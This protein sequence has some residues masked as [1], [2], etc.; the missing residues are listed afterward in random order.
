MRF[1]FV[2]FLAAGVLTLAGGCKKKDSTS[3]GSSLE[4]TYLITGMALFGENM[5]DE[6]LKK[7][8]EKERTVT[9]TADK[10]V[11]T[12]FMG[13]NEKTE[14]YKT[15][16]SKSPAHIDIVGKK[17]NGMENNQYGVFKLDGDTLTIHVS[18]SPED[19]PKDFNLVFDEKAK[20]MSMMLTMTKK[21]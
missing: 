15:D 5:P 2:L 19:R 4:G 1:L 13:G 12:S 18:D 10:I 7:Q 3:G 14:T 8:S 20:K 21:K 11:F 6:E 16:M 17:S 9:F